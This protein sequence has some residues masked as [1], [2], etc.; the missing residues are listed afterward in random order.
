ML[1]HLALTSALA[2]ATTGTAMAGNLVEP[3]IVAPPAAIYVDPGRDWSGAYF[4]VNGDIGAFN[5]GGPPSTSYWGLGVHAGYL[6]DMG[7]FVF[8]AE[9]SYEYTTV[10][11]LAPPNNFNRIGG[12]LILGYDAGD[13]MPHVTVGAATLGPIGGTWYTGW[14]AGAGASVMVTDNIMLTGRYRYTRYNFG[15]GLNAHAGKLMLSYRF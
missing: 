11:S 5:I 13:F 4:G 12:D 7:D 10:P 3:V 14:S 1:K 15:P 9:V 6:A 2:L 8:G